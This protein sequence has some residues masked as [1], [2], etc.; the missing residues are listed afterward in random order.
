V[1]DSFSYYDDQQFLERIKRNIEATKH[2]IEISRRV[3]EE[4]RRLMREAEQAMK[5]SL[6]ASFGAA[7]G[8]N[9]DVKRD[10][11]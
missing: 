8:A 2:Q 5:L 10:D 1:V 11:A 9:V 3:I 4:S 6:L 7:P